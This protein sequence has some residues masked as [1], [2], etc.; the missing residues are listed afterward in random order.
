MTS[1]P[2]L[3]LDVTQTTRSLVLGTFYPAIL[4]SQEECDLDELVVL[5]L[6]S[7]MLDFF[8]DIFNPPADIKTQVSE[9]LKIMQRPQVVYSPRPERTVRFC[10]QTTVDDFENQRTSTSHSALE[11]LL[12]G[13]IADGNLNLKEKKKH[14]KQVGTKSKLII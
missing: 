12:E 5:Q 8:D 9:R 7:F 1:N 14:L 10:Q 13:I 6:V 4:R 3:C 2:N 11:Q